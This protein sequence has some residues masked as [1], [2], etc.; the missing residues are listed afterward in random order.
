MFSAQGSTKP[1]TS[2]PASH[3]EADSRVPSGRQ[4]CLQICATLRAALSCKK[5]SH[6]ICTMDWALHTYD[7]NSHQ[8]IH[9]KLTAVSLT[10]AVLQGPPHTPPKTP[11]ITTCELSQKEQKA[12]HDLMA[13]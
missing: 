7:Q 1:T 6:L 2:A 9:Q 5:S 4:M 10:Y 11:K 3:P 12:K 13:A 8:S